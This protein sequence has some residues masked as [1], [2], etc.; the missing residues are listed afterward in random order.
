MNPKLRLLVSILVGVL[1]AAL[2]ALASVRQEMAT[3]TD[4]IIGKPFGGHFG[5]LVD[6]NGTTLG[7]DAFAKDYLLVFFGFTYCPS[8]CPTELQKITAALKTLP[9][10]D[11]SKIKPVFV[12]V[13]PE[14]DTPALLK[15][16]TDLFGPD[17]IGLTGTPEAID[18]VKSDWKVYAA[19]SPSTDG[20]DYTVDHSAFVYFRGPDSRLWGLFDSMTKP[21]EIAET[22]KK[23]LRQNP[24]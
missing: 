1:L 7:A 15:T 22:I 20:S 3:Q 8:I 24:R 13:D 17:I 9:V 11:Q 16:Y 14:R 18:K 23:V 12:S 2:I 6:E 19:K 21:Q 4:G 10:E 5:G